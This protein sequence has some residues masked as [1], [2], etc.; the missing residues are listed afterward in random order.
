[1]GANPHEAIFSPL[2]QDRRALRWKRQHD[3]L[4]EFIREH[5]ADIP[6]ILPD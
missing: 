6:L 5:G 2:D 1:L 4:A 3:E